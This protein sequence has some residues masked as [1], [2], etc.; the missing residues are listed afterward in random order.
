MNKS[1][2]E[3]LQECI[4]QLEVSG[5][6]EAVLSKYP[7]LADE[8]RPHLQVWASL[9]AV[10]KADA[11]PERTMRGRQRLVAAVAN[12]Q[13]SEGGARAM[14]RLSTSGGFALGLVGAVAV[15]AAIGLGITFLTGNLHV[16]FGSETEAQTIPTNECLDEVLGGYADPTDEFTIEDLFAL[17][18]AYLAGDLTID[19]I[20]ALIEE[21]R[22]CFILVE[23]PSPP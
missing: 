23:P 17:R 18:D 3:I 20:M 13:R 19:D 14:R 9:S 11:T 1:F 22:E 5:D 6:I 7:E 16:D 21:L 4:R 12:T 10:E 2:D 15:V 8:L